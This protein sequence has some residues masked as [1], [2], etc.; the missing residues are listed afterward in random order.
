M[1][2]FVVYFCGA[3]G[4]LGEDREGQSRACRGQRYAASVRKEGEGGR[5]LSELMEKAAGAS[6]SLYLGERWAAEEVCPDTMPDVAVSERYHLSL[7]SA[8]HRTLLPRIQ[9]G[10]CVVWAILSLP[11][12]LDRKR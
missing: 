11:S 7:R 9:I 8:L 3:T 1:T 10:R 6:P 2:G 4:S 5:G 12:P